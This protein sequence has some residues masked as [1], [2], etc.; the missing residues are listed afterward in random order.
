M[1]DIE[2]IS[3]VR[4]SGRP[5]VWVSGRTAGLTLRVQW[6]AQALCGS[7]SRR[8]CLYRQN[9]ILIVRRDHC[10]MVEVAAPLSTP[11]E[12]QRAISSRK[13]P[14]MYRKTTMRR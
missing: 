9:Q 8:R 4:R 6:S 7:N 2:W 13:T 12:A 14:S 11:M 1:E 5:Q 3:A 10:A